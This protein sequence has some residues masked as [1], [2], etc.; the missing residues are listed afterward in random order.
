MDRKRVR[1]F[2][3][4]WIFT[5]SYNAFGKISLVDVERLSTESFMTEN[6]LLLMADVLSSDVVSIE[7]II[8]KDSDELNNNYYEIDTKYD[9]KGRILELPL[10][11]VLVFKGGFFYNGTIIGAGTIIEASQAQLFNNVFLR[12]N[13]RIR[14]FE[15]SW[16]GVQGD[17]VHDDTKSLNYAIEAIPEHSSLHCIGTSIMVTDTIF[18][19]RNVNIEFEGDVYLKKQSGIVF[20]GIRDCRFCFRKIIGTGSS[21]N[22]IA[23]NLYDCKFCQ[24]DFDIIDSCLYGIS[25]NAD[26]RDYNS[27]SLG[28]NIFRFV[29]IIDC[30]KGIVFWGAESWKAESVVWAEGNEFWGGFIVKCETGIEMQDNIKCGNT[31]FI[32]A[33]D[34]AEVQGSHD[35]IDRTNIDHYAQKN[36]FLLNFVRPNSSIMRDRDTYLSTESGVQSY[37]RGVYHDGVHIGF[38]D[39]MVKVLPGVIEMSSPNGSYIDLKTNNRED[40]DARIFVNDEAM[41]LSK[42]NGSA[43]SIEDVV[44]IKDCGVITVDSGR[45]GIIHV[46]FSTPKKNE[47]Y[48]V[49]FTPSWETT[50]YLLKKTK[51][52]FD[53]GVGAAPKDNATVSWAVIGFFE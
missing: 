33:I 44:R 3:W 49:I 12:G 4:V 8:R 21:S 25:F 2:L 31:I 45:K 22:N 32:G 40:R 43:L 1:P 35:I 34:C 7:Q 50:T 5:C 16:F 23:L 29:R 51:T 14:S 41:T 13:W 19:N 53:L 27:S 48:I 15:A 46:D 42:N 30:K 52:G 36:V 6:E 28:Q 24:F 39:E 9:L 10:N 26:N 37:I 11:C 20:D 17:G 18:I 47:N 38:N